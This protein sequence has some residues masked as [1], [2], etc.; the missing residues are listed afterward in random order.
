[1]EVEKSA[2]STGPN[3]AVGLTTVSS[4]ALR[5]RATKSHAARSARVL[6]LTYAGSCALK[7]GPSVLIEGRA[8]RAR[9]RSRWRRRRRSAPRAARRGA[10]GAQH[11]QRP[12]ARRDDEL[13][14]VLRRGERKGRGD[15]QHVLAAGHGLAPAGILLA[16][17]RQRNARC[18]PSVAPPSRSMAR[19]SPARPSCAP[20]C[21]RRARRRAAARWRAR[22]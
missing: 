17:P 7:V 8:P 20:W 6:D 19:T 3:T 13:V 14:L 5:S 15:V 16:G 18:R 1:M 12:L 21:A 22:R 9:G 11:P 4:G 2:P 10:R